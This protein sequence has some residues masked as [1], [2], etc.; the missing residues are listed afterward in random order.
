MTGKTA[1]LGAFVMTPRRCAAWL[2]PLMLALLAG[3]VH[4]EDTDPTTDEPVPAPE[5]VAVP[6]NKVSRKDGLALSLATH[7]LYPRPNA[8]LPL[9]VTIASDGAGP[10]TGRLRVH[11]H[12]GHDSLFTW[13]GPEWTLAH[14]ARTSEVL[15][16]PLPI[17]DEHGE[18]DATVEWLDGDKPVALDSHTLAIE[19]RRERPLCLGLCLSGV[20]VRS[21]LL[22]TSIER[23]LAVATPPPKAKPQ[24][25]T[26]K[27]EHGKPAKPVPATETAP[28]SD[29]EEEPYR[30][31]VRTVVVRLNEADL[32]SQPLAWCAFD[33][34]V[35]AGDGISRLKDKQLVAL[36]RWTRGGGSLCLMPEGPLSD[37]AFAFIQRLIADGGKSDAVLASRDARQHL[38][39][40]GGSG[41]SS[42]GTLAVPSGIGRVAIIPL[43]IAVDASRQQ[44]LAWLPSFLWKVRDVQARILTATGATDEARLVKDD[45]ETTQKEL[46]NQY[47]RYNNQQNTD[48]RQHIS[49]RHVALPMG[50]SLTNLLVPAQ[51]MIIPFS[52]VFTVF[53]L[54]VLAVGP[55]DWILLGWLRARRYTWILFPAVAIGFTVFMVRLSRHYLGAS[56][57]RQKLEVVDYG[58]GGETLRDNA[59]ELVFTSD[60]AT[61]ATE[62]H[63]ALWCDLNR[64]EDASQ[65]GLQ[66]QYRSR[67]RSTE[68]VSS[69]PDYDGSVPGHYRVAQEIGQ[70]DP[71]L[72]RSLSFEAPANA[73]FH[74]DR[75]FTGAE[76]PTLAAYASEIVA[77]HPGTFIA[78][79]H[80]GQQ[81]VLKGSR[82]SLT[83]RRESARGYNEDSN[84]DWLSWMCV[85]PAC[86][87]FALVSQVSPAGGA[88]FEDFA[89]L[90][91]S[92]ARQWLLVAAVR[93]GD[94][95]WVARRM[96]HD[97]PA[98]SAPS[99]DQPSPG[100]TP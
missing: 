10:R 83:P 75:D 34:V 90:D 87:W 9:S 78:V 12:D 49:F 30:P 69:V 84:R 65:G 40:T 91:A 81:N 80:A 45:T 39:I 26:K 62:V 36:E 76:D 60:R 77:K 98:E 57:N 42:N 59:V 20:D 6:T 54:F 58:H 24:A 21:M 16:P 17:T 15:L 32:T 23:F 1:L 41:G 72:R 51:V 2:P 63:D 93:E 43:G 94:T 88:T 11:V 18:L 4:A 35:L 8:P 97:L 29:D 55:G 92:D 95:L 96:F 86:G 22:L 37:E 82:D 46:Q 64:G 14:G 31:D 99:T 56:D 71:R 47:N 53:L 27:A 52:V 74:L 73:P 68:A 19:G 7:I 33:V 13:T 100:A 70:W 61:I 85:H 67:G 38:A 44:S 28:A 79:Y 3:Y 89:V 5:V 25:K 66:Y 50:G 48:E